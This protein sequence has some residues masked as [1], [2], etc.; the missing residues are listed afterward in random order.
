MGPI[1][2]QVTGMWALN[3]KPATKK[4]LQQFFSQKAFFGLAPGGSDDIVL[5]RRGHERTFLKHR[6]GFLKYALQAGYTLTINYSFGESD[7]YNTSPVLEKLNMWLL[8]RF[9][10]VVPIF[11]GRWWFPLL[12]RGDV[13]INTVIGEV[14]QLP[15]I[16]EPT[17][18]DVAMWHE[19]YVAAVERVFERHKH[20]FGY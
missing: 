9:G 14:N 15:K 13:E 3:L 11:W 10:F 6:A 17:A 7:L 2:R 12:P 20:Q 16:A 18:E 19:R 1:F 8:K 5:Y 4:G